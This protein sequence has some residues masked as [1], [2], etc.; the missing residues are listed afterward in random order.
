MKI[1]L[2]EILGELGLPLALLALFAAVLGLF[3]VELAQ[4]LQIVEGLVGTFTLIALLINVLKWVGVIQDNTAGKWSAA[5]NLVV[6][7]T[8]AVIFKLYPAFDFGGVDMQ[9]GEF[10]KVAGVLFAYIIQLVGSKRMHMAMTY[11]LWIPAFSHTLRRSGT[12]RLAY[13]YNHK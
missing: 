6:V 3:G 1:D 13:Q 5:A 11:G 9:I 8:V 10:A 4:I 12:S 7:V 2:K